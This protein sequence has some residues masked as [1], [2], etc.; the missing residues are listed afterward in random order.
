MVN[1]LHNSSHTS[2]Q[3][4]FVKNTK[5]F[6]MISRLRNSFD[7]TGKKSHHPLHH[8][9]QHHHLHHHRSHR[10]AIKGI[11]FRSAVSKT[12]LFILIYFLVSVLKGLSNVKL[13]NSHA[14]LIILILIIN[15]FFKRDRI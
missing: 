9:H 11:L 14:Q 5:H 10:V 3:N 15:H 4:Y 12:L 8:D 13:E 6:D 7:K 1:K 2:P